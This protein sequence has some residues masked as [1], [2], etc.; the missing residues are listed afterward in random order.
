MSAAMEAD[1]TVAFRLL[2]DRFLIRP[3][4]LPEKVG[5]LFVP[6]GLARELQQKS[7]LVGTVVYMGPGMLMR[8]GG[9]WPMPNVRPG[10]RVVY[11]DQP[12]PRVRI[13]DEEF[14]SIREEGILGEVQ[15]ER[16]AE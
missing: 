13:G 6:A 9:R 16:V 8:D 2:G 12:W 7:G 4:K 15:E 3:D 11:L 5:S 1:R 14:L 10:D